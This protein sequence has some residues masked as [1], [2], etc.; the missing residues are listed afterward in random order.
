MLVS[1]IARDDDEPP[2]QGQGSSAE[3]G[4][5]LEG[6]EGVG[7][8]EEGGEGMDLEDGAG[9][10]E[11][12]SWAEPSGRWWW[13]EPVGS[14]DAA[15]AASVEDEDGKG[16]G[17]SKRRQSARK[18]K[19]SASSQSGAAAATVKRSRRGLRLDLLEQT[20]AGRARI[21]ALAIVY[22][23]YLAEPDLV[24][25]CL[26]KLCAD[27]LSIFPLLADWWALTS[28]ASP[29]SG[30]GSAA[31]LSSPS[32]GNAAS[33]GYC[34]FG[35][36]LDS[37]PP[38]QPQQQQQTD[39]S[40]PL[41]WLSHSPESPRG[42]WSSPVSTM[43]MQP[44]DWRVGGRVQELVWVPLSVLD[45]FCPRYNGHSSYSGAGQKGQDPMALYPSMSQHAWVQLAASAKA[46][47]VRTSD[48]LFGHPSLPLSLSHRSRI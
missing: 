6:H 29:A 30:E 21:L 20:E 44:W 48:P 40:N 19:E 5:D 17:Q 34:R 11:A 4:M 38:S 42:A 36:F 13:G 24:S 46:H 33:F 35:T 9:T 1:A 3:E 7:G 27:S 22:R 2:Q 26:S 25:S 45:P 28:Q 16:N 43:S 32:V 15:G 10:P 47:P 23:L 39:T 14:D 18:T 8:G 12:H 41:H 37:Q 31:S